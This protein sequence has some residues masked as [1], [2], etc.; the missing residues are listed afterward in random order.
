MKRN[1]TFPGLALAVMLTVV[2]VPVAGVAA[3]LQEI[4]LAG[5]TP[6]LGGVRLAEQAA[7][8]EIDRRAQPHGLGWVRAGMNTDRATW[9]FRG[10]LLWGLPPRNGRTDGPRGLIRLRYPVLPN[11]NDD[12]IN[13]IAIPESLPAATN[14]VRIFICTRCKICSGRNYSNNPKPRPIPRWVDTSSR[15][16]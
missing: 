5:S 1:T 6:G 10:G 13:F 8:G 3:R 15:I 11:G 7:K 12:L 14:S 2:S 9:G 4:P 16:P